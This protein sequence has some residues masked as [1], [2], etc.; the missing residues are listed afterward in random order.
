M[1][2]RIVF[3]RNFL[4]AKKKKL[5]REGTRRLEWTVFCRRWE[6]T[7]IP[8]NRIEDG[9]PTYLGARVR[10]CGARRQRN[11]ESRTGRGN[12]GFV[13]KAVWFNWSHPLV[14]DVATLLLRCLLDVGPFSPTGF[15]RDPGRL[16]TRVPKFFP[17]ISFSLP[18][19]TIRAF[20]L[21]GIERSKCF[22]ILRFTLVNIYSQQLF[23][24]RFKRTRD[25]I[26]RKFES[27]LSR[28]TF[29]SNGARQNLV[30]SKSTRVSRVACGCGQ[31]G[32]CMPLRWHLQT[33][34]WL[35][36]S[37]ATP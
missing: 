28:A 27:A 32:K 37:H 11:G 5:R 33:L 6:W 23:R 4:F 10:V 19:A 8:R 2:K 1:K 15:N 22:I 35:S 13:T 17:T 20:L 31:L 26:L 7:E 14:A 18:R 9:R 21:F 29:S 36:A 34:Q 25:S 16:L 24:S 30:N 12:G 3:S